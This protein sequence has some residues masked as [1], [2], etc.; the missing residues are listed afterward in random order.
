MNRGDG[1]EIEGRFTSS[2]VELSHRWL[3]GCSY[4]E[5]F[6]G[7]NAICTAP[8]QRMFTAPGR[9]NGDRKTIIS[10]FRCIRS[11]H[12]CN[13]SYRSDINST[14]TPLGLRT[15]ILQPDRS[16]LM[17]TVSTPILRPTR[18]LA[19]P[20]LWI[21]MGLALLSVLVLTEYPYFAHP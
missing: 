9:E 14:N 5:L 6:H 3:L 21:V 16:S 15:S 4:G 20:A 1:G 19:K 13:T 8:L 11:S 7:R 18:S 2:A 12:S 17:S 10:V